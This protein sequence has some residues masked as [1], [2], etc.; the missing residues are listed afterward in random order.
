MRRIAVIAFVL[1][2]CQPEPRSSTYFEAHPTEAE[3]VVAGC[4]RGAQRGGECE[5]AQTGL[6]SIQA[7]KRLELFRKSAE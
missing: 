1:A 6:A 4:S 7:R 5:A 2:S 3:R